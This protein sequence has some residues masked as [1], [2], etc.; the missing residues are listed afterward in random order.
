MGKANITRKNSLNIKGVLNVD[1]DDNR[2]IVEIED[3]E[4]IELASLLIDFNGSE[5]SIA[6][7]ESIDIA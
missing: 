3:G 4:V 5:V 1:T 2:I 6:V 7:G